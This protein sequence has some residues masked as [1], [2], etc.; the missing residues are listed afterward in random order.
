MS[1][2]TKAVFRELRQAVL[3]G[4]AHSRDKLHHLADN[5]NDHLDNVVRQVRDKDKFDDAPDT[6]AAPRPYN[7][8]R[9]Q[10]GRYEPGSLPSIDELRALTRTDPDTAFYW[11]GRDANGV[12]VGPGGSGIAENIATG[13][14][15]RTL[16]QTLAANGVDPLPVWNQKDPESV[17]FWEDAS[18]AFAENAS[19]QVRAVVGSDLRPGNIWQTVEIPRLVDNPN[20]T[21]IS[22]LDPDTGIW[23]QL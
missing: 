6:P 21:S 17:R 8:V 2:A 5:M 19:G 10:D 15:G 14:G 11:S 1:S 12:G 18:A 23:A 4:T 7:P 22:Q 16:E 13:S 9:G 3:K 20:V